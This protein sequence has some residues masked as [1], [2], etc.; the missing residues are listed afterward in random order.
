MTYLSQASHLRLKSVTYRLKYPEVLAHGLV[1][2]E[3]V[4]N[5]PVACG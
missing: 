3:P 1:V 5:R 4:D 2:D